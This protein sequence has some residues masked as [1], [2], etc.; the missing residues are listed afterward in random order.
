M[1][2]NDRNSTPYA[3]DCDVIH[4]ASFSCCVKELMLTQVLCFLLSYMLKFS[5][6]VSELTRIG[7]TLYMHTMFHT[8]Y[9]ESKTWTEDRQSPVLVFIHSFVVVV[10]VFFVLVNSFCLCNDAQNTSSKKGV[11]CYRISQLQYTQKRAPLHLVRNSLYANTPFNWSKKK[12]FEQTVLSTI[13]LATKNL[14][15][16]CWRTNLSVRRPIEKKP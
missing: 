9:E 14:L 7:D 1:C 6:F 2:I 4:C 10:V 13:S 12:M 3:I 5:F 11:I 15:P 16:S 8:L